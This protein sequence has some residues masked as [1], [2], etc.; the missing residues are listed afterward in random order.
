MCNVLFS[1]TV[2]CLPNSVKQSLW[3]ELSETVMQSQLLST[4]LLKLTCL[5]LYMMQLNL[6][7][8]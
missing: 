8:N 2:I 1:K 5:V 7:M 6:T 4:Q 3:L